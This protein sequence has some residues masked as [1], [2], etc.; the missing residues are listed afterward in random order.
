MQFLVSRKVYLKDNN[1]VETNGSE[2]D[3][4]NDLKKQIFWVHQNF[5]DCHLNVTSHS[6]WKDPPDL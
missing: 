5:M 3:P 4:L 2:F 1:M 6:E